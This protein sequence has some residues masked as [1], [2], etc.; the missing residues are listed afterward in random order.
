MVVGERDSSVS[1]AADGH[2]S[3]RLVLPVNHQQQAEHTANAVDR[4]QR[5]RKGGRFG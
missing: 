5:R 2:V 3:Y 4:V 1:A